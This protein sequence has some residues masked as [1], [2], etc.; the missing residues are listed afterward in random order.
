MTALIVLVVLGGSLLRVVTMSTWCLILQ[1]NVT[2]MTL[3]HAQIVLEH[4]VDSVVLEQRAKSRD[5]LKAI[6]T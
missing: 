2:A 5:H 6:C 4:S 3:G 1:E